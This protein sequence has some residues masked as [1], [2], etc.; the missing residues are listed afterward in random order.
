MGIPGF[1]LSGIALVAVSAG[2]SAQEASA[3]LRADT[4]IPLRI[5]ETVS[6]DTHVSGARFALVVT[7]D[8]LVDDRVV[9][10]AGTPAEGEVIHAGKSGMFGKA[11]E[12]SLTSRVL[13]L[14]ERRIKLR[15][16]YASSGQQKADLALGVGL[17]IPF[18]PFF[19]RGKQVLVP[20]ETELVARVAA[21]ETFATA[22]PPP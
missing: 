5:V 15:S 17:F 7:E 16:L 8:V 12:L 13:I 1:F 4:L 2:S 18:A 9:V 22:S 20:A 10:P 14:G 11:G 6:S 19:I 3:V 21:D